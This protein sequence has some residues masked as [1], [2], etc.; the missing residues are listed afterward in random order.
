MKRIDEINARLGQ[1]RDELKPLA[2]RED[3]F[4]DAERTTWTTLAGEQ[5]LL[6]GER[7]ELEDR[8]ERLHRADRVLPESTAGKAARDFEL[9]EGVRDMS[10]VPGPE[11]RAR[12]ADIVE[13]SRSFRSDDHRE[14]V[15]NLIERGGAFGD[16]VARIALATSGDEY[17]QAWM[18]YLSGKIP[19]A[20]EAFLLE[21]AMTAGTGSSGGYF[22]PLY[23][24]PTMILTG[25]GVYNEI[26]QHSDVRQ[27]S[28]LTFNGVTAAQITA[29][30]ISENAAF[31][32][33]TP[34]VGQIQFSM[35]KA[36]AYVPASFE[37]FEDI[38]NLAND[39]S[40]LIADAK[41][42]YEGNRLTVGSGSGQPTG[43]VTAVNARTASR[44]SP[45]TG[46]AFVVGDVYK[47]H[48]SLDPRFRRNNSANRMFIASV[49]IINT[50]RQFATANVY[51]AFLTDLAGGQPPVLLGDTLAETSDM[52]TV[53]TTGNKI[54]LYGD[55]SR[56]LVV[57]RVGLTTEFIPNVFDQSTGRPSGTRAWLAHWRWN[58]TAAD[59]NAFRVLVL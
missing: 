38:E 16:Y 23:L 29:S 59:A 12:A 25:A 48:Q 57:D 15:T 43:V 6:E 44:V 39:V 14:S 52:D 19:N 3:K 33:N 2:S 22:V 8:A 47:L 34:T 53:A 18:S 11:A 10:Q 35:L 36:G 51:H 26:R 20:R 54:L 24:D 30:E 1:I 5:D 49:N 42:N 56:Y 40:Q 32:D 46:G 45:A 28:T 4:T 17:R 31:S 21:R 27:I 58:A 9:P 55:F 7:A 50:M 41:D 37:A 13:H